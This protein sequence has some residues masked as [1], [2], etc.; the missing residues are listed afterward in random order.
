MYDDKWHVTY[1]ADFYKTPEKVLNTEQ[2]IDFVSEIL[3]QNTKNFLEQ[4]DKE[5]V[6]FENNGLDSLVSKSIFDFLGVKYKTLQIKKLNYTNLQTQL[7][8]NY[9]GFNQIQ[10]FKKPTCIITGFYG[11][12]YLL[13][14][15]GYVQQL[16][17]DDKNDLVNIFDNNKNC[18]MKDFFDKFYLEKCKKLKKINKQLVKQMICNDVQVWHLDNTFVFSPFKD[19]R[20]LQLLNCD[21]KT[22]VS[23][24]TDGYI[25][26]RLIEKFNVNLVKNIDKSKNI[27]D[28]QWFF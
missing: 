14:N 19:L 9:Y 12:E 3:L 25:S 2:T 6:T 18:Y 28:P 16:I 13:R 26:K 20:F 10:A 22:I 8:K 5:L 4:N 1:K 24:V 27:N 21:Y 15:P 7:I 17:K 23:Q 11:D